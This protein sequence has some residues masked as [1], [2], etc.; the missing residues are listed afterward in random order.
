MKGSSKRPLSCFGGLDVGPPVSGPD[1]PLGLRSPGC[2]TSSTGP[3]TPFLMLDHGCRFDDLAFDDNRARPLPRLIGTSPSPE[4]STQDAIS[5]HCSRQSKECNRDCHPDDEQRGEGDGDDCDVDPTSERASEGHESPKREAI[6]KG[7]QR[8]AGRLNPHHGANFT[9]RMTAASALR[10][11]VV[12]RMTPRCTIRHAARSLVTRLLLYPMEVKR[13]SSPNRKDEEAV[14]PDAARLRAQQSGAIGSASRARGCGA[15]SAPDS[16]SDRDR[17]D[18]LL[19]VESNCTPLGKKTASCR[20][21]PS[22]DR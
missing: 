21:A 7:L 15:K 17:H 4:A 5:E 19:P 22:V 20:A 11:A 13:P 1:S 14:N 3:S 18:C 6:R 10:V 2:Q 8:R 9:I 12:T 16:F